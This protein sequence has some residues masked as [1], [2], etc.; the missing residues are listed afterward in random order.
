APLVRRRHSG[1]SRVGRARRVRVRVEL[2]QGGAEAVLPGP[3]PVP[4]LVRPE[5]LPQA[6]GAAREPPQREGRGRRVRV[7]AGHERGDEEPQDRPAAEEA[8]GRR[9]NERGLERGRGGSGAYV[10]QGNQRGVRHISGRPHA[11]RVA[12]AVVRS[13]PGLPGLRRREG[14]RVRARAEGHTVQTLLEA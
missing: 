11:V 4:P 8:D 7:P 3:E 12:S 6:R 14:L 1:H 9:P 13:P 10:P 5:A 2:Q